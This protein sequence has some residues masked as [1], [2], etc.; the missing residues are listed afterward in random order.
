MSVLFAKLARLRLCLIQPDRPQRASP[1]P[2][3]NPTGAYGSGGLTTM[4]RMV[5]QAARSRK[6]RIMPR[7]LLPDRSRW[8]WQSSCM[9]T[10]SRQPA[11]NAPVRPGGGIV[12]GRPAP[13]PSR[14]GAGTPASLGWCS[15]HLRPTADQG[16]R[17]QARVTAR[18]LTG[19]PRPSGARS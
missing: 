11:L 4:A 18:D 19:E 2:P 1:A 17:V 14:P 6:S 13:R 3:L 7:R 16:H 15:R 12:P 8:R 10:R 9:V 5:C